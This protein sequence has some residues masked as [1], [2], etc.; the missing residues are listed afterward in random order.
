ME[1]LPWQARRDRLNRLWTA[2]EAFIKT[3]GKGLS[4]GLN[5]FGVHLTEDRA[6]LEQDFLPKEYVL[7]EYKLH[8]CRMCLCTVGERPEPEFV[9]L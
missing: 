8:P 2:K 4:M 7:H 5:T 1:Q 6:E 9:G 3:V